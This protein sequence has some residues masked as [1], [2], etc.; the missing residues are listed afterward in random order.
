MPFLTP[1]VHKET[2]KKEIERLCELGELKWQPE[3]ERASPSFI[4]PK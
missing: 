2:L 3:S 1:K 4:V